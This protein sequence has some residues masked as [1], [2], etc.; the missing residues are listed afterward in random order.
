MA[1]P[2]LAIFAH[3]DDELFV[4]PVLANYAKRGIDCY[5]AIATDGRFGIQPHAGGVG[6]NAIG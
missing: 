3:P 1:Q 5:L 4:S 2:I 6:R